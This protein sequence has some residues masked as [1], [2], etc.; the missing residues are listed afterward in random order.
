MKTLLLDA[1]NLLYRIFWVN[2][3][4]KDGDIN[5]STLMFLRSVKSYVDK[6]SPG[7]TYAVWDK[8]LAYPSTNFRKSLSE[9]KYKSNR[10]RNVAKE[11]HKN[12]ETLREL[13]DSLG[14]KSIYPNRMEADDVI[15]WL[16]DKLPG[17]KVI[18]TVDKDLY[19]LIDENTMVFNPIQKVAVTNANFEIYT[20][21]VSKKNFLDYKAIVGDNS[22]NLKGL[23]KVGH[24]RAL[25]LLDKFNSSEKKWEGILN[26]ENYQIYSHNIQMMDLSLGWKYYDDEEEA[27]QKQ[28]KEGMPPCNSK[29]FYDRCQ[30][31]DLSSIMK[32]KDKWTNTFF[33][34]DVFQEVLEKVNLLNNKYIN[35][36]YATTE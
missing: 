2:K 30:E 12:D 14:I 6:F 13:L 15:S 10:D 16:V 20:K 28:M 9:N 11:A 7:Q 19:Q 36:R 33:T 18:I 26:E 23:H 24:K 31:L 1:N 8:R 35:N 25:N 3:N 27:Y 5:M 4:K 21:G 29:S 34:K 22:D 32:N 17:K